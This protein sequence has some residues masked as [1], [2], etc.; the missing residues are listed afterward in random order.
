PGALDRE[1]RLAGK[2]TVEKAFQRADFAQAVEQAALVDGILGRA[3]DLPLGGIAQ[4]G[5]LGGVLHLVVVEAGRAAIDGPQARDC[6]PRAGG[7]LGRRPP[8]SAG[9]ETLQVSL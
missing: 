2:G 8:D 5:A 9:R 4:P 7:A 1:S 6:F 3:K